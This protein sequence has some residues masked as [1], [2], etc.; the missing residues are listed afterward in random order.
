MKCVHCNAIV[1]YPDYFVVDGEQYCEACY[2]V[3]FPDRAKRQDE[4]DGKKWSRST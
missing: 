2:R 4:I 3:C 1:R